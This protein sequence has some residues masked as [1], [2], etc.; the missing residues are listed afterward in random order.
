[1]RKNVCLLFA[2]LALSATQVR[3]DDK[4]TIIYESSD[5]CCGKKDKCKT[6]KKCIRVPDVK[7]HTEPAYRCKET[8]RCLPWCHFCRLGKKCDDGCQDCGDGKQQCDR[9]GKPRTVRKLYKRIITEDKCTTKCIVVDDDCC[10]KHGTT[11]YTPTI[12]TS[13]PVKSGAEVLPK[14][15]MEVPPM[16][17]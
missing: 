3:A 2:A 6:K 16:K 14:A 4:G 7:K 13:Q 15:P 9:C 11:F 10:D 17:K 8:E 1:M 12:I 5:R